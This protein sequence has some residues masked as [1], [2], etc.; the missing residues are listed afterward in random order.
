MY[1]KRIGLSLNS[2]SISYAV[3]ESED[4]M[5]YKPITQGV[6]VFE[7]GVRIEKGKEISLAAERTLKRQARNNFARTRKR[8]IKLVKCLIKHGFCPPLSKEELN[9]WD[10]QKIYPT[11]LVFRDWLSVTQ[12]NHPYYNRSVCA[13][14]KLDLS[15]IDNAYSLGR[16]LYHMNQRRGYLSNRLATTEESE[17][18]VKQSI[19]KITNEKGELTLGQYYYERFQKGEK[20]RGDYTGR[21]EHYVEEFNVIVQKQA[22]SNDVIAELKQVIFHQNPLKSQ[23]HLIGKCP[24]EKTKNKCYKSHPIAEQ[25]IMWS[26]INN[27]KIKT[28]DDTTMRKLNK[29]E[30]EKVIPRFYLKRDT[31]QFKDIAKQLAPI[32]QCVYQKAKDIDETMTVF[33][34]DLNTT[35][36]SSRTGAALISFFGST[37]DA[38]NIKNSKGQNITTE[39]IWHVWKTFDSTEKLKS[40]AASLHLDDELQDKFSKTFLKEGYINYSLK[41]V[42][43]ILPY[44]KRGYTLTH[45]IL[46]ANIDKIFMPGVFE[47]NKEEIITRTIHIIDFFKIYNKASQIVNSSIKK[48]IENDWTY[49]EEAGKIYGEELKKHVED[50]FVD[51]PN[52][53]EIT[54]FVLRTFASQMMLNEGRGRFYRTLSLA[55]FIAKELGKDYDT[56][57]NQVKKLYNPAVDD[58]FKPAVVGEDN[59]NY[60]NAPFNTSFKNPALMR[61]MFQLKTVLNS[62]ISHDYINKHT[63]VEI[64]FAEDLLTA[65]ERRAHRNWLMDQAKKKDAARAALS[66]YTSEIT[67]EMIDNYLLWEEQGEQCT[68]TGKKIKLFDLLNKSGDF[69][70]MPI[71]P[72]HYLPDETNSNVILCDVIFARAREDGS[73]LSSLENLDEI[74]ERYEPMHKKI[75]T[76]Q[77][78]QFASRK[79]GMSASTKEAK[80]AN[81]ARYLQLQL[82]INYYKQKLGNLSRKF[83]FIR[84]LDKQFSEIGMTS[85][86]IKLFVRT[87]FGNVNIKKKKHLAAFKKMWGIDNKKLIGYSKNVTEACIAC[88]CPS[89]FDDLSNYYYHLGNKQEYKASLPFENFYKY[90]YN[91]NSRINVTQY[92]PDKLPRKSKCRL[93]INGKIVRDKDGNMLYSSGD[94]AR[95]SLHKDSFYG[96]R[97]EQIDGKMV[98]RYTKRKQVIDLMDSDV[99]KIVDDKVRE[100]IEGARKEE[101]VIQKQID[102][103]KK[104]LKKLDDKEKEEAQQQINDLIASIKILY[105]MPQ[106]DGT[107]KPVNKVKLFAHLTNPMPLKKHRDE[108]KHEYKRHYMVGKD[109]NY[110]MVVYQGVDEDS[111]LQHASVLID[112]LTAARYYRES[113]LKNKS[114]DEIKKLDGL[115]PSNMS[116]NDISYSFSNVVKKGMMV[117][118]YRES[119]NEIKW[120]D[121]KILSNRL[122]YVHGIE[123]D[124][125]VLMHHMESRTV[126]EVKNHMTHEINAEFMEKKMLHKGRTIKYLQEKNVTVPDVKLIDF[127]AHE[128]QDKLI[129][130]DINGQFLTEIEDLKDLVQTNN[131]TSARGGDLIDQQYKYPFIR[132]RVNNLKLLFEGQDFII[133]N[134]GR[135]KKM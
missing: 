117:L 42:K 135:I 34:Y 35:I 64:V 50:E 11:D 48:C 41:A 110:M 79:N 36:A 10:K 16:A 133:D 5:I 81:R 102:E 106:S 88:I 43:K 77:K 7:P 108:S 82:D 126:G 131:V 72:L 3:L 130:R 111:N 15:V 105:C 101:R 6:R 52:I 120:N 13:T 44:L 47:S 127:T 66:E 8:K 4:N 76:L 2:N 27:I 20:I 91:L 122:Y 112:K 78:Y 115:V 99:K 71:I 96:A 129:L 31:F 84:P 55:S 128:L 118:A 37:W 85:K 109:G 114:K 94:S 97:E 22:L 70:R 62:L 39:D 86:A 33:N 104:T 113:N 134:L 45:A 21:L 95:G 57:E 18:V 75:E 51:V 56:D 121:K 103:L 132:V 124:C 73:F 89:Y 49:S 63:T 26:F 125:L 65:N 74:K 90:L 46:L 123:T 12:F 14:E 32:K 67:D 54:D 80:D 98:I 30:I 17:G 40:F 100:F 92:I 68:I 58:I 1:Q 59:R 60:L 61:T 9:K 107:S 119:A 23:K 83:D 38:L 25:F 116:V 29:D 24:F 19:D 93:K 87:L 69:V 53:I 28:P